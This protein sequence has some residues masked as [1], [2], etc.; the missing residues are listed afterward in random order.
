MSA[1]ATSL[2]CSLQYDEIDPL[3]LIMGPV[4]W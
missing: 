4:L 2:A 1:R 3:P